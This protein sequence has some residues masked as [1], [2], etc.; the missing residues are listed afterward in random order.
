MFTEPPTCRAWEPVGVV[1]IP[2]RLLVVSTTRTLL[3]L[4][5][6]TL[7]AVTVLVWVL[8]LTGPVVVRLAPLSM[9]I[10]VLKVRPSTLEPDVMRSWPEEI[11][12]V[13]P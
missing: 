8:M 5:F 2:T 10:G 11:V 9:V 1:L 6:W 3:P 13:V 4:A 12:V 7:R